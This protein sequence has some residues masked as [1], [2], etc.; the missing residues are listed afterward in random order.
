R[1]DRERLPANLRGRV[2]R[3]GAREHADPAG[4]RSH[5]VR[6]ARRVA[7]YHRDLLE[8]HG[9]PIADHLG[10]RGLVRLPLARRAREYEHAPERID[11]NPDALVGP[12]ARVLDEE[13]H[14]ETDRSAGRAGALALGGEVGGANRFGD[15]PETLGVVAAVV[16]ARAVVA[17][18]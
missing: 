9:E 13:G 10:H 14:T 18:G 11:P 2:S 6:N 4:E 3:R 5:T 7:R 17:R 15:S 1:G 12:E 16:S 8:R